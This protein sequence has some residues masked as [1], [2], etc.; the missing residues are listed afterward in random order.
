MH[1]KFI[2]K[3]MGIHQKISLPIYLQVTYYDQD[4]HASKDDRL[5]GGE[6]QNGLIHCL[7]PTF[8][9]SILDHHILVVVSQG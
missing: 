3:E 9:V 7:L 5:N 2:T 8:F 1:H 4:C 6:D